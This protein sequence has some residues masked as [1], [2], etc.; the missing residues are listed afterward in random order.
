MV[1]QS[2]ETIAT[3]IAYRDKIRIIP[4]G[5]YALQWTIKSEVIL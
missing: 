5:I 1:Y 3:A 2:T 4:T